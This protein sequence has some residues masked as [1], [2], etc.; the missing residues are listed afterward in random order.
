MKFFKK[1]FDHE[2]KELQKF[3]S[4]ARE[5]EALDCEYSKLSDDELK[6]KT[7][8]F[9]ERLKTLIVLNSIPALLISVALCLVLFFGGVRSDFTNYIKIAVR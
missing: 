3:E 4:I 7:N 9:K 1:I 5:I 8:I 2:Y 6:N